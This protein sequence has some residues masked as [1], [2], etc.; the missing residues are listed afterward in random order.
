MLDARPA[1]A[2]PLG[3]EALLPRVG[4]IAVAV[5]VFTPK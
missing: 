3:K 2:W 1:V 4:R 5:S